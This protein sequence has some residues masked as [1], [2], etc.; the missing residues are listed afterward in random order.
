LQLFISDFNTLVFKTFNRYELVSAP[1]VILIYGPWGLGKTTMLNFLY[2]RMRKKKVLT[3]FL[4]A[5]SFSQKYAYAAQNNLLLPFRERFRSLQLLFIDDLQLLAGKTK[6]L[7]ELLYT[8]EHLIEREGKLII[9]FEAD[10]PALGFLGEGLA[11]RF[12]G[13]LVLT[14]KRP[15]NEEIERFIEYYLNKR[16]LSMEQE[17]TKTLSDLV[18][19]LR[20]TVNSINGFIEFSES[21]GN[22][23]TQNHFLEYLKISE[24]TNSRK[25][26]PLNIIKITAG[27]TDTTVTDLLG[28]KRTPKISEARQLAIYVIRILCN[29]SYSEIGH[30]FSRGHGAIIH[31]CRQTEKRIAQDL[32]LRQK[33]ETINKFFLT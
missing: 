10:F 28:S 15:L 11:S 31:A 17:V 12:L 6:T 33:F 1:S 13:G 24:K 18:Y 26:E 14:I 5:R 27:A 8:Y 20:M 3:E 32:Y 7:E 29:I 25:L 22:T 2:Q 21:R 30:I 23:F 9:S 19:N 16:N 4:N